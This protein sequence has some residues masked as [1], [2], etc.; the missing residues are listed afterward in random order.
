MQRVTLPSLKVRQET[1]APTNG[2]CSFRDT[3]VTKY[4][5]GSS[6]SNRTFYPDLIITCK[7]PKH[8]SGFDLT[9]LLNSSDTEI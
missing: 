4:E 5:D 2:N 3:Y 1:G 9:G 6:D 7:C 8:T